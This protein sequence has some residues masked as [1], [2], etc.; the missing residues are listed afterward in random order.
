VAKD[1]QVLSYLLVSLLQ[2][3]L[4]QVLSAETAVAAWAG[5]EK[6]FVSNHVRS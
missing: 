1:R 2:E 6:F 3:I 5:I 4:Q